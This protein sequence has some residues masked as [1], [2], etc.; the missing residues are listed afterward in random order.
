MRS[1]I[2]QQ[3]YIGKKHAVQ[4]ISNSTYTTLTKTTNECIVISTVP[5]IH[6]PECNSLAGMY[7]Y[8]ALHFHISQIFRCQS[9]EHLECEEIQFGLD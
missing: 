7:M 5:N 8:M 1:N 6:E 2:K 4:L 9:M 3:K